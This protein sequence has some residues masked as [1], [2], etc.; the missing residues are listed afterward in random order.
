MQ[1]APPTLGVILPVMDLV[2]HDEWNT[3][4]HRLPESRTAQLTN[5]FPETGAS[6]PAS[7][8]PRPGFPKPFSER[9]VELQE[10]TPRAAHVASIKAKTPTLCG[11]SPC[12][13]RVAQVEI[14]SRHEFVGN[15]RHSLVNRE[16]EFV[17]VEKCV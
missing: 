6:R 15:Q 8:H 3:V 1:E 4:R 12:Y 7:F 14:V 5:V 17:H 2:D 16:M 13:C 9:W 10:A 11:C